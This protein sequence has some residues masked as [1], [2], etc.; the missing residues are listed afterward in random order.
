MP[1]APTGVVLDSIRT[2]AIL[3]TAI[4]ERLVD[5]DPLMGDGFVRNILSRPPDP[6]IID[7]ALE[8]LVL[9]GRIF[10]PSWIPREWEGGL[11][12]D[13]VIIPLEPRFNEEELIEV[14]EYPAEALVGLLATSGIRWTEAKIIQ[15]VE[16]FR[17]AVL[18]W[19]TEGKGK[20]LGKLEML[21]LLESCGLGVVLPEYTAR[22]L[23]LWKAVNSAHKAVVP[24]LHAMKEYR[25]IISEAVELSAL[26]SVPAA[27]F[28]GAT[29]VPG[30]LRNSSTSQ[31][32]LKLTCK[33]LGRTPIRPT[34]ADT[35]TL[36]NSSEAVALREKLHLWTQAV[37]G[38]EFKDWDPILA[39]IRD[40]QKTL[41][42]ARVASKVAEFAT[43]IGVSA[44]PAAPVSGLA[45]TAGIT[46]TVVGGIATAAGKVLQAPYRWAMFGHQV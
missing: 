12:T 7:E 11:F 16:E 28:T 40:A 41:A 14:A 4:K 29:S 38:G 8:Q 27:A 32:I 3:Y 30:Q 13:E 46:A 19:E 15:T 24:I 36:A 20:Q 10:S 35:I 21:N 33:H 18:R 42:D 9:G 23:E 43:W 1:S 26:A 2:R 31:Y 45:A 34:L 17:T 39:E 5:D 37:E 25:T 22:E 6:Q 44:L